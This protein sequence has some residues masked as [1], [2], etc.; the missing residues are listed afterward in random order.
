MVKLHSGRNYEQFDR[1]T[2]CDSVVIWCPEKLKLGFNSHIGEYCYIQACGEIE[3]GN[4]CLIGPFVTI[5]SQ[6]HIMSPNMPICKS[7]AIASKTIIGNDVYICT[8]AIITAGV[9]IGD[10][11]VIG[12]GAVV[13]H[14]VPE[15][16]IW[17]EVPAKK[18][19]DRRH[20]D[21][22]YKRVY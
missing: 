13:T 7:P 9:H 22:F 11:A 21:E 10:H 16:E 18:I 2:V 12:A 19:G 6:E 5:N 20:L 15:W 8:G 1:G 17:G 4:C 3:I 14:D